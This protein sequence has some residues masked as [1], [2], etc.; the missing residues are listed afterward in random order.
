MAYTVISQNNTTTTLADELGNVIHV[1][2][3]VTLATSTEYTV[4]KVNN[5]TATLED[6]DGNIIRD[7][8]CVA[9]L[10]GGDSGGG[11]HPVTS[12]NGKTGVVVLDAKDVSAIP[13]YET[14]PTA[15]ASN[16]GTVQYI[17]A[18]DSTYTHNYFYENV[19]TAV[20]DSTVSF[21]AATLSSSTIAC[22][23]SD[24]AAF[25][26]E[27]GSG[28][29]TTITHGTL[30]Y[31][32]S[33]G[34]LVFVGK[35]AEETTVCTFQL[36]TEDYQDAGFTIT[37]TLQDGDVFA[38]TTAITE[39]FTYAWSRK[40]V[41]PTPDSLPAQ[42]GNSGKFLT[43]DG[44]N[45]SWATVDALPSQ[46]G[47]SGR[48]LGTDGF[49]AGWVKPEIVQ[50]SALPVASQDEEGNIYQ[51]IGTTDATYTNG[52]FYKCVSDGQDPATYSWTAVQVQASA[53]GLPSQAGNGGKF[54]TTDGTDA[55]WYDY[56]VIGNNGTV[57]SVTITPPDTSNYTNV[58]LGHA[59][60]TNS[61]WGS[62]VYGG[63]ANA[64]GNFCTVIGSYAA[65]T[66]NITYATAVGNE[67]IAGG[68]LA[69]ALGSS[70][71]A[72]AANAIQ[73]GGGTNST[74]N[75]MNVSLGYY[76]G[77]AHNVTLLTSDETIPTDRFTTTPSADGTYVPTLTISSG[78]ATRSWAAPGGGG[79]SLP[80]Q[81]GNAG[82]FLTTDGTD[83]S[84]ATISALQNT[85]TGQDAL[86]I[87]GN[88]TNQTYSINIGYGSTASGDLATALGRNASA[89]G[90][91]SVAIGLGASSS[92]DDAIAIGSSARAQ[93]D[94][95]VAI[96]EGAVAGGVGSIQLGK[97]TGTTG[98]LSYRKYTIVSSDGTIPADR[99]ASTTGLADGNYRL[100][101]TM[102]SGV[103]TLSWVAE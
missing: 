9:V 25:V 99:L 37:G 17:G 50:R 32:Q 75:S 69:L 61:S 54:L 92:H 8:P 57:L 88:A 6:G 55:S 12:V 7:V 4:T 98:T 87:L 76:N 70:A 102:A 79:S 89:T 14:M 2:A 103:P 65:S 36:Y 29:I 44:T 78:V 82:K 42:A 34:L 84:W 11:D 46:T 73:L 68:N 90:R 86:T 97:N 23:G 47:Y 56:F 43:T 60:S 101:L 49:V 83:A 13:Q 21:E 35:D 67:A 72:M 19:A 93:N 28:D 64:R 41:Q 74:A 66:N 96:G 77:S 59:A 45:A 53:G 30:T 80:S 38:F 100:R 85:A 16:V 10:Y 48:V 81:T 51:F 52:Y 22:S 18:T 1:P 26:A 62:T 39:S 24:F 71:R 15:G 27:W 3:R 20:Y 91:W 94:S 31:D 63:H 33:G 95:A 58:C 5:N 40:D